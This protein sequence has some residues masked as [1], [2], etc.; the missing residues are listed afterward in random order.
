[1]SIHVR[2]CVHNGVTEYHLRYPGMTQKEAQALADKIN[3]GAL[4][5]RGRPTQED[6]FS[7]DLQCKDYDGLERKHKQ[8]AWSDEQADHYEAGWEAA[9]KYYFS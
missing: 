3:A 5:T 4:N 7:L 6:G 9:V 1:M 8:E 2:A